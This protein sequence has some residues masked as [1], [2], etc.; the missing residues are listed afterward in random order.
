MMCS[1]VVL[2]FQ[3]TPSSTEP[4]YCDLDQWGLADNNHSLRV[5]R[6]CFWAVWFLCWALSR[7]LLQYSHHCLYQFRVSSHILILSQS[8]FRL[9]TT[10]GSLLACAGYG[11]KDKHV[12]AALAGNI[13]TSYTR[14]AE[15]VLNN[16]PLCMIM[17]QC[18]VRLNSLSLL[19]LHLRL[20]ISWLGRDFMWIVLRDQVLYQCTLI[21]SGGVGLWSC[22]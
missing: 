14:N 21:L 8:I 7:I 9:L 20:P 18:M 22:T 10:E 17:I 16:D 5:G 6:A 2:W 4:T 3:W 19:G 13:W 11:E 15:M 12:A 1:A